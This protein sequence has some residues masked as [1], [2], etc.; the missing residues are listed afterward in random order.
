MKE[1]TEVL[2]FF[3]VRVKAVVV[4]IALLESVTVMAIDAVVTTLGVPEITP[5]EVLRVSP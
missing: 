1:E 5:E 2:A 3:T 4:A